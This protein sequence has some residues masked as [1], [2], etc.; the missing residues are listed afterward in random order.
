MYFDTSNT[1]P[2]FKFSL[3][4]QMWVLNYENIILCQLEEYKVIHTA[5]DIVL[6]FSELISFLIT[7]LHISL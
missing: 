1:K 7:E 2:L 6:I 4:S 5:T 3:I